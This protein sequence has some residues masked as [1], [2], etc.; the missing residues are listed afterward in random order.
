[1]LSYLL[2]VLIA[3]R[4]RRVRFDFEVRDLWPQTLVDMGMMREESPVVRFLSLLPLGSRFK[5]TY[6]DSMASTRGRLRRLMH[7]LRR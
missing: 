3:A 5:V 2:M 7:G 4:L 6:G 1:M